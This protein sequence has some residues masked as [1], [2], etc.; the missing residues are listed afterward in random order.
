M[1]HDISRQD[2]GVS[3]RGLIRVHPHFAI[4][5]LPLIAGFENSETSIYPSLEYDA[6]RIYLDTVGPWFVLSGSA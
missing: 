2:L 1:L 3:H 4:S 6:A 5:Y